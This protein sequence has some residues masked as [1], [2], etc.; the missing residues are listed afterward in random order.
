MFLKTVPAQAK[1]MGSPSSPAPQNIKYAPALQS[2]LLC[3]HILICLLSYCSF[4]PPV[5]L[6][7]L[8]QLLWGGCELLEQAT[9]DCSLLQESPG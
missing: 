9:V 4:L 7:S 1:S 5:G 3:F 8:R 6:S 2:P